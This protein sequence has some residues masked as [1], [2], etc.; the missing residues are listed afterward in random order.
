MGEILTQCNFNEHL[1]LLA[2]LVLTTGNIVPLT[3]SAELNTS[4]V[5]LL[6]SFGE[7]LLVTTVVYRDEM[8]YLCYL[9]NIH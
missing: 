4:L 8:C 5:L 9:T 1:A 6:Y 3:Q 7:V 2:G